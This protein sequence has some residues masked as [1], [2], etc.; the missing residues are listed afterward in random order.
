MSLRVWLPLNGTLNNCGISEVS[1]TTNGA[2][3]NAAGKIGSCYIFDGSDDFISL[4]GSTLYKIFTGS[5]NAFSICMWIY[6]NDSTRAILFGDFGLSGSINFN[7]ELS[8]AHHV[9]FYWNGAP[10]KN[11]NTD[12]SV[13]LQTW[14]HI[15]LTYD[16]TI[17]KLYKNGILSTDTWTGSLTAKTKTNGVYYLGRDSRTGTT[18]FNGRLNDFRIY[19]HAL[20]EKEVKEIAKGL[21]LHY[22]L[23]NNGQG[24]RNLLLGTY[25]FAN[26]YLNSRW[27]KDNNI[28][29][30]KEGAKA[31]N[32]MDSPTIPW[33]D[34]QGKTLTISADIRSDNFNYTDGSGFSI[35]FVRKA[36]GPNATGYSTRRLE[37]TPIHLTV[38]QITSE[39]KRYSATVA[40]IS[41]SSFRNTYN[42]GGGD[43]FGIYIWNYTNKSVQI[44]NIKLE[45]GNK[46]TIYSNAPEDY[47]FSTNIIEDCSGYGHHGIAVND[48][49]IDQNSAKY[50]VSTL[51]SNSSYIKYTNFNLPVNTWTVSCWYYKSANPTQYE[52][53]YCLSK[54]TG[55]DADKKFAAQPNAGRIWFK[56]ESGSNSINKLAINKWTLLT[57]SCNG[58]IGTI[59][60]NLTPIGTINA[61]NVM[62]NCTDL[63]L[64]AKSRGA[65]VSAIGVPY[66]GYISDFRIYCTALSADNIKELYQTSASIDD[67][68]NFYSRELSNSLHDTTSITQAGIALADDFVEDAVA[69]I[70]DDRSIES[71]CFYEY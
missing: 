14:T 13:G 16:G 67:K 10:D 4:T 56:V 26:W 39:W 32:D 12:S 58:T 59:Y 68:Q 40:N 50:D 25:N 24:G 7:I 54:N 57:I 66:N 8:T 1:A 22:K 31:W 34:V 47:N 43:W 51:F 36:S 18:A 63:V 44:K 5:S 49:I 29:T 23:D 17:L 65:E 42:G 3:I 27:T 21:V 71:N 55:A 64:G 52:T 60:E 62:T 6:H 48:L 28:V 33:T 70:K 61:G 30:Y 37:C 11:F 20:S 15:C 9:R 35:C 46:T 69:A 45:V 53:I 19:D 2:T 38:N 41:D